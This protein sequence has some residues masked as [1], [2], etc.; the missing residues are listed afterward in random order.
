VVSGQ[1]SVVIPGGLKIDPLPLRARHAGVG[2]AEESI[3]RAIG[4]S[5]R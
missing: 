3:I 1:W 5:G 2:I 4:I